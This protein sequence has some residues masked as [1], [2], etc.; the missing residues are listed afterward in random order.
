[1]NRFNHVATRRA[2]DP[3]TPRPGFARRHRK[4][5]AI[6]AS[7]LL[8]LTLSGVGYA[9]YLNSSLK[10]IERF[11]INLDDE[12]RPEQAEDSGINILLLGADQAGQEPGAPGYEK[13]IAYWA[14]QSVWPSGRYNSDAIMIVHVSNNRQNVSAISIPRDSYV[15]IY[16]GRG[17]KQAKNKVNKALW[18]YGP[19]AAVETVEQFTGVRIDHLAMFDWTGFRDITNALGGIEVYVPE[20][21]PSTHMPGYVFTKGKHTIKGDIALDYVR[22]RV[23]LPR[24]D[25]SRIRRQQNVLRSIGKK[26]IT[27]GTLGNPVRMKKTL[28]AI[29]GNLSLDDDWSASDIRKLMFSLRKVSSQDLVFV[30][31]PI[32][33][34]GHM[35]EGVGSVVFPDRPRMAELFDAAQT[36]QIDRFIAKYPKQALGDSN[37]VR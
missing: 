22:E 1:M 30:T 18:K 37:E 4:A 27:V 19:S 24:S 8:V 20:T 12:S 25:Y 21:V 6:A 5:F 2:H 34:Y 10:N 17:N 26:M 33:G 11:S 14:R 28:D 15:P 7:I 3:A 31:L 16:D 36:N 32:D 9:L 29:T 13:S 35:I 23:N